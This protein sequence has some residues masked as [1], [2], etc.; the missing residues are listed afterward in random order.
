MS[1]KKEKNIEFLYRYLN[2]ASPTGFE[3]TGQQI[4][5]DYV[6]PYADDYIIDTYGSAVAVLNPG[7][8]Y[9]VVIEAHSDEI[10]WFVNYISDDGYIYVRR[11]GGSDAAI[12]PSDRKSTRLNS[13][14]VKI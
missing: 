14:H 2:N 13:S 9:K 6:R 1:A 11:N 12:A 8:D 3:V 5:L 10:S 4:W 7:K